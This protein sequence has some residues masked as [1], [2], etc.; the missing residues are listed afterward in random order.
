[1]HQY[2]LDFTKLT[3]GDL[4]PVLSASPS[5]ADY[6]AFAD[7][8]IEGGVLGL[9]VSELNPVLQLVSTEFVSWLA[10]TEFSKWV[11]K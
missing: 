7:T 10:S 4:Q 11:A 9:P 8:V 1:M 5:V 2:Q 6:I 3:I